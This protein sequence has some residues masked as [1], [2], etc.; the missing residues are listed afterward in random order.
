[1]SKRMFIVPFVVVAAAVASASS[2]RSSP[3]PAFDPTSETAVYRVTFTSTWTDV[4]HPGA[5]PAGGHYSALVGATHRGNTR[6]W[7][8]RGHA[9]YGIEAMAE[10]GDPYPLAE[11]VEA[12]I[13]QGRADQV[14]L[15]SGLA[16][17]GS[18]SIVFTARRDFAY[19]TLVSMLAPSPDWF[20][21]VSRLPLRAGEVWTPTIEIPL[22]PWDAGTD[23]GK[24]FN[25]DDADS[26][27]VVRRVRNKYFKNSSPPVGTFTIERIG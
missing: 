16:S 27:G 14:L 4:T 21:G 1:M 17:P 15:G 26:S 19:L 10:D 7:H 18:T 12:R 2:S 6:F 8:K 13:A 22:R 24:S 23:Q 25:S 5:F 11:R 20:V 3:S 9:S